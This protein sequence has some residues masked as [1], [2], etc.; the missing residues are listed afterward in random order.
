M[1]RGDMVR[2]YCGHPGGNGVHGPGCEQYQGRHVGTQ[3]DLDRW[4]EL[5][6]RLQ[7]RGGAGKHKG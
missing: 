2:C 3:S 4:L 7:D 6:E 1:Y 5:D